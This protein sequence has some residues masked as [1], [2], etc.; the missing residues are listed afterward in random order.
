MNLLKPDCSADRARNCRVRKWTQLGFL[1]P[2]VLDM[3]WGTLVVRTGV[4]LQS[5]G[6]DESAYAYESSDDDHW[7][8]F[9]ESEQDVYQEYKYVPQLLREAVVSRTD[10]QPRADPTQHLA[11]TMGS[12]PRCTSNWHDLYYRVWEM[13]GSLPQPLLLLDEKEWTWTDGSIHADAEPSEVRMENMAQGVESGAIGREVRHY[14]LE[15][16]VLKRIDPVALSPL[17][18]TAFWLNQAWAEISPWTA[19]DSRLRL[20]EW[21]SQHK[22]PFAEPDQIL[23]CTGHPDLWQLGS[24]EGEDGER[25]LYFLVGWRPPYR[26][27]MVSV[28]NVP[29]PDCTERDPDA[30]KDRSLFLDPY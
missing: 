30:D 14:N 9:W 5:C 1:D 8:R 22:G 20:K 16:G 28:G 17:D 6:Y 26:F 2:I 15:K 13:K 11:V 25:P 23:H 7:R 4:G 21:T 3:K 27:S 29:H 19:V 12:E 10:F 24:A 18:F